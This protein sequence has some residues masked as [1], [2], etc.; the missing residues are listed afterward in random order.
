M[1]KQGVN[2]SLNLSQVVFCPLFCDQVAQK[3][4]GIFVNFVV[5]LFFILVALRRLHPKYIP[6]QATMNTYFVEADILL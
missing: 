2:Q 3:I 4:D 1:E 6:P 5:A